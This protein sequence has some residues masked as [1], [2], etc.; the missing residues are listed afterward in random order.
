M[1]Y[2][3]LIIL[4][5]FILGFYVYL[6]SD[7]YCCLCIHDTGTGISPEIIHDIFDPYFTTKEQGKG[8]GL[9]LSVIHGIIKSYRGAIDIQSRVG[10]GISVNVYLP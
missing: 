5:L 8:S 4:W 7:D 1:T 10:I 9:G 3:V 2:W 6:P